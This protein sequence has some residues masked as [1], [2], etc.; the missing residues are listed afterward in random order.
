MMSRAFFGAAQA[1]IERFAKDHPEL[2]PLIY[3]TGMTS[4]LLYDEGSPNW[5][6]PP[7]PTS[8]AHLP[9]TPGQREYILR[10]MDAFARHGRTAFDQIVRAL[11]VDRARFGFL[12]EEATGEAPS[13]PAAD[14]RSTS[15]GPDARDH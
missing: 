3:L 7:H 14:H 5:L 4:H 10:M 8:L 9:I 1:L 12:E 2:P 6:S 11:T 13:R 15:H